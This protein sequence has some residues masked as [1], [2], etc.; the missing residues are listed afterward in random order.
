MTNCLICLEPNH[1]TTS[2]LPEC[3]RCYIYYHVQCYEGVKRIG[4]NC[5]ICRGKVINNEDI[6]CLKYFE[7]VEWIF[8]L[9]ETTLFRLFMKYPNIFTFLLLQLVAIPCTI[10]L[11]TG[12]LF[13]LCSKII[14]RKITKICW[15]TAHYL[16]HDLQIRPSYMLDDIEIFFR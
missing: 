16:L 4:L 11:F 14:L 3:G 7:Y 2:R 9:I 1:P 12:Y 13:V 8:K 6:Y 10:L 5:P 15:C